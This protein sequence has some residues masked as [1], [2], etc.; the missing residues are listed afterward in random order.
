MDFLILENEYWGEETL[1]QQIAALHCLW[2]ARYKRRFHWQFAHSFEGFFF[3]K[4]LL[5]PRFRKQH[6]KDLEQNHLTPSLIA[7]RS[8]S[9]PLDFIGDFNGN[10][11]LIL[12]PCHFSIF[13]SQ[14]RW[15]SLMFLKNCSISFFSLRFSTS[16]YI[17]INFQWSFSI[18][19]S[20][21][22]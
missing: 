12:W 4:I 11:L 18:F 21:I 3:A 13:S 15:Y 8:T 6:N 16:K 7:Y 14:E 9:Q 1:I 17:C 5:K 2:P 20:Y 10:Y 19:N 22:S